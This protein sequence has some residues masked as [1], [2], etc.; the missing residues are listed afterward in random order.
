M[1]RQPG[2]GRILNPVFSTRIHQVTMIPVNEVISQDDQYVLS[3]SILQQLV[4]SASARFI[5]TECMCRSHESCLNHP[6]DLGCLFLGDGATHIHPSMGRLCS[7]DEAQRHIQRAM[8]EGLYPLIAHTMIDAF[9][10]G[11]PYSRMLTI[12]FCCEC[13]CV[14]HR[15]LRKGPISLLQIVQR[16]P[17]LR[18]LV[19]EECV[20]CGDCIKTCPVKAISSNHRGV[21]ISEDCKGC[22]ICV[23]TCP[24]GAIKM[25]M[26]G[27]NDLL[28]GFKERMKSYA[29]ISL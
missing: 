11:I 28:T 15:G 6:I 16:L 9:T 12:C 10:L 24:Y 20:E 22:G 23:N 18:V 14:V 2:I 25:V 29:D 13:C 26:E 21:E 3:F 1:G 5:M 17:G 8:N 19:G 27:E 4:K 7:I